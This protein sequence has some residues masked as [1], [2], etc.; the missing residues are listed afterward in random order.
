[1]KRIINYTGRKKIKRE[2]ISIRFIRKNDRIIAF[3][4]DRL[5]L[6]DLELPQNALL[7]VEAY[8][9]T[10]LKRFD[11]GT[12]GKI[13]NRSPCDLT[14]LAYPENLRFRIIV[15]DSSNKKVL[16]HADRIVPDKSSDIK[17]ILPVEFSDLGNEIWK[18]KYE[19]DEGSPILIINRNI[20]NI[21]NIAKH[22]PQ[23]VLY[24]YPAIFREILTYIIFVDGLD[25]IIEPN[26]EWHND[27]LKF[28]R[29]LGIEIPEI[30]ERDGD[31]F[32][33]E[34]AL[35]WIDKCVSVFS[36]TLGDKFEEYIH[37]M[38]T[39]QW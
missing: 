6:S 1:M 13:I 8:Y 27:W 20:P 18:I 34:N 31:N 26:I 15:I 33:K 21:H 30:L 2:N 14:D 3:S 16:A 11:F 28:I 23:F 12:A 9:R 38:E 32:D 24:V 17:S 19:G 37:K 39:M 4:V 7:Y 36:S 10:E 29:R 22:D 35:S 25:S 5:D